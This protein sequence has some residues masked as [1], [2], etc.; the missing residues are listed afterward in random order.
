MFKK[1]K[2]IKNFKVIFYFIFIIIFF[3]CLFF[4]FQWN[5]KYVDKQEIN[6]IQQSV[7]KAVINC[8]A[9][10]GVYPQDLE[11][12]EKNYGVNIDYDKYVVDYQIFAPNVL[13]TIEVAPKGRWTLS[14]GEEND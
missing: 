7:K 8:Y 1:I 6:L 9:I 10:E 5:K 11:Y 14:E 12:I 2:S 13:P 4:I 3:V